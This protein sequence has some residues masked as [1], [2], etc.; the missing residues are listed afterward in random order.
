MLFVGADA[1]KPVLVAGLGNPL[2]G[3]EGVG[4]RV[5]QALQERSGLPPDVEVLDLGTAGMK[6]L[7]AIRGRRRAI[8]VDCA[9][10]GEP[11]GTIR[12]FTEQQV[13]SRKELAGRSLHETD[14]LGVL[15]LAARLGEKPD[16]VVL[17]GIE[18]ADLSAGEGLSDAL[19]ARLGEYVEAV[20][21]AMNLFEDLPRPK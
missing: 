17:F 15:E 4:V 14:L 16:E 5:V 6:L 11:P 13:R 12:R 10:M 7:H 19:E 21:A 20:A 8:L 9:R 3:D 18:P 2:I 1:M